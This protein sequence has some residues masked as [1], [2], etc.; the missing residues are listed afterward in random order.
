VK[1]L[2]PNA[3]LADSP[4]ADSLQTIMHFPITGT[5][6]NTVT[7]IVGGM[8]GV[9]LGN[10]LP[11]K[12]R[13]TV[14]SGLGL[15]TIVLGITMAVQTQNILIPLFSVL[16]GGI[17]GEGLRI[18]DAL[19]RLGRWFEVRLGGR[20]GAGEGAAG[21]ATI[22]QGFVTASLVFCVGPLT[23]LGSI[24]DG[25]MADYT[26]LAIKSTLDGFAA[27]ALAASL[28]AGVILSAATVLGFQGA[29]SLLAIL[30][31][32]ALGGVTRETPWVIEM[33]A[34]GGIVILS[35][36]FILLDIKRI[37]TANLLPAIFIAPAIVLILARLGISI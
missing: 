34:T 6:L 19:E 15:I 14:L 2:D 20:L 1:Q 8:L 21:S 33:T 28:G 7:V 37:R 5:L 22:A 18:E 25:L 4:F 31:G 32:A 10:R 12:T 30:F 36:G 26:L 24:Q 17:I 16:I 3:C 29:I 11:E 35:I 9:L 13:Q 23:I 27:M